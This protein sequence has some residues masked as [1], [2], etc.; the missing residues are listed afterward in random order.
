MHYAVVNQA[1][2]ENA[3][4][5]KAF[6]EALRARQRNEEF[7]GF[8]RED[9]SLGL[10]SEDEDDHQPFTSV[11]VNTSTPAPLKTT[12]RKGHRLVHRVNMAA[13]TVESEPVSLT[14]LNNSTTDAPYYLNSVSYQLALDQPSALSV[15]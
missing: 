7:T 14:F 2:K 13:E 6:T 12:Y 9:D 4:S 1:V 8:I 3:A 11:T 15:V 5:K 10:E